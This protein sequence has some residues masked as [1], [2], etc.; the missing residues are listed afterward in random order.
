MECRE[1][2]KGREWDL[3]RA[4][5]LQ[6]NNRFCDCVHCIVDRLQISHCI[7]IVLLLYR[8]PPKASVHGTWNKVHSCYPVYPLASSPTT[9]PLNS[10]KHGYP[11]LLSILI[12]HQTKCCFR[13]FDQMWP[14]HGLSFHR[15][16]SARFLLVI[17]ILT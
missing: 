1:M 2:E 14:P 5:I 15:S 9:L 16:V 13:R 8:R 12:A 3:G 4:G 6:N 7:K 10:L 17:Q 11:S